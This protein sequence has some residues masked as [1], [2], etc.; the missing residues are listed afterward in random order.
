MDQLKKLLQSREEFSHLE[1]T[2]SD[3]TSMMLSKNV[4]DLTVQQKNT[5]KA[6]FGDNSILMALKTKIQ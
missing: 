1:R 6:C 4:R 3:L 2:V 5:L